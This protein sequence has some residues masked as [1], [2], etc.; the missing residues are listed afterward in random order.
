M[1]NQEIIAKVKEAVKGRYINF[2]K[3]KDLGEG[4]RKETDMKIRLGVNYS[5]MS[6]N[7]N[8]EVGPLPWGHYLPGFENLIIEHTKVDKKTGETSG[9][10]YYLRISSCTPEHPDSGA[11]VIATRYYKDGVEITKDEALAIIGE[12]KMESHASAVYNVKFENIIKIGK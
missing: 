2:T 4:V 9:P 5:N 3:E 12:K 11:D 7:K 1:T 8:R 10:N 6:I